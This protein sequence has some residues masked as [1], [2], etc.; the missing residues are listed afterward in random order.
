MWISGNDP[1]QICCG[2]RWF[3][4]G[5]GAIKIRHGIR[6]HAAHQL[7]DTIQTI[8][9]RTFP[10]TVLRDGNPIELRI[11]PVLQNG[12]KMI[13][14]FIQIPMTLIK[15]GFTD[16]VSQSV[17]MNA[18]NAVL[19]FQ[20]IGR[21]VRRQASMK[22]LDGPIGIVKASGEAASIGMAALITLTAAISL[23]LG[24]VNLLPIPILDGGVMLL[25]LIEFVMGRDLSLRIKE[26]IVQ[27]SMVFLL[28]MMVV[29]LYNDVL[30]L[31]PR[32]VNAP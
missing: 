28:L 18:E 6:W 29:V 15:L 8:P 13:G 4:T 7:T 26:R 25:L 22:Q 1:I 20:V 30:K 31:L 10:I 5:F 14:V 17:Q 23:N 24:L 27:V 11:S 12:T 2:P 9:D 3:L 32:S 21:L 19:I 16:A